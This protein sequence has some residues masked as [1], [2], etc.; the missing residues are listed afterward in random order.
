MTAENWAVLTDDEHL[1]FGPYPDEETAAHVAQHVARE[2]DL[3]TR[4]V[5]LAPDY[6]NP[7]ESSS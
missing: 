2:H 1:C 4:Y 6:G 5:Q 3:Y 7:Q